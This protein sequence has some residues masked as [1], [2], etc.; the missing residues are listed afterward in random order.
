M[1]K[2]AAVGNSNWLRREARLLFDMYVKFLT[3]HRLLAAGAARVVTDLAL[4]QEML[5]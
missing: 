1:A 3:V 5:V 4:A 2:W